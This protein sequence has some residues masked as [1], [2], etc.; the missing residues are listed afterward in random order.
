MKKTIIISV[1]LLSTAGLVFGQ[2]FQRGDFQRMGN[3]PAGRNAQ[4][5]GA[6]VVEIV[7]LKGKITLN[8]DTCSSIKSGKEDLDLLINPAAI[9]TLNLKSGDNIEVKGFKVPGPNW[10]VTE[11]SAVKVMEL[12]VNGKTYML[13]GGRGG[14]YGSRMNGGRPGMNDYHHRSGNWDYGSYKNNA[15]GRVS[16]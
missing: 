2:N 4:G 13:M 6:A 11:K 9:G 1:I 12:T 10:S 7:E 8:E 5:F 15:P 3:A 14:N 16:R